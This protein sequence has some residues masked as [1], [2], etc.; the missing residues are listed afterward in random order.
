MPE[1]ETKTEETKEEETEATEE[2]A[3]EETEAPVGED[4]EAAGEDKDTAADED[5]SGG[6]KDGTEEAGDEFTAGLLE[7]AASVG[8]DEVAARAFITAGNLR[9]ALVGIDIKLA[10]MG[11]KAMEA[12]E[13]EDE[14]RPAP[15]PRRAAPSKPAKEQDAEEFKVEMGE[16]VDPEIAKAMKGVVAHLNSKVAA[17]EG[18]LA[19]TEDLVLKQEAHGFR[20]RM[21]SIF[22]GLDDEF[23]EIFGKEPGE[24]LGLNS[25]QLKNRLKV[26][27]TCSA[28]AN[29]LK[30]TGQEIPADRALMQ[31]AIQADFG[32]QQKAM[33]RKALGKAAK[34]RSAQV[35]SRPTSRRAEV[36]G[37]DAAIARSEK[38]D[39]K[40]GTGD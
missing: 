5:K 21:D 6:E 22:A 4:K 32:E 23:A 13:D 17:L 15:K 38:Y 7:E 37:R 2:E 36:T 40:H 19:D 20:S 12:G 10:D 14:T 35:S 16:D 31:R 25:P 30:V 29:G 8:Y 34:K 26:M 18:K 33:T 9:T 24:K 1:V 11:R 39:K 3:T 28:L 27:D